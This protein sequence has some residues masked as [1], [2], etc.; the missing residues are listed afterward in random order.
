MF[1]ASIRYRPPMLAGTLA[2][3]FMAV[4]GPSPRPPPRPQ[5][6]RPGGCHGARFVGRP[7]AVAAAATPSANASR[8]YGGGS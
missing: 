1:G 4:Q 8:A 6:G 5:N 7:A 3:S 2:T